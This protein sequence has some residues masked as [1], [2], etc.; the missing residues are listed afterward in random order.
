MSRSVEYE[1]V[2]I[3]D[4]WIWRRKP[5][6]KRPPPTNAPARPKIK[7]FADLETVDVS[8]CEEWSEYVEMINKGNP[9]MVP[10]DKY[11]SGA[12]RCHSCGN[13][14][15]KGADKFGNESMRYVGFLYKPHKNNWRTEHV[16]T[17]CFHVLKNPTYSF[18]HDSEY[19]GIMEQEGTG[20]GHIIQHAMIRRLKSM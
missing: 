10:K 12:N 13:Y 17:A 2:L 1:W 3:N 18:I 6:P 8:N 9:L 14:F 4:E 20:A 16:C 7:C 19:P 15:L 11:V 5:D